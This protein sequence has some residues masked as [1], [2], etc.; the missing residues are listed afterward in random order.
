MSNSS[1]S[2]WSYKGQWMTKRQIEASLGEPRLVLPERGIEIYDRC[3]KNGNE[4]VIAKINGQMRMAKIHTSQIGR[5]FA[6]LN[7]A[8]VDLTEIDWR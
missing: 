2:Q 8:R 3:Y 7:D 5:T 6:T 4:I 1:L